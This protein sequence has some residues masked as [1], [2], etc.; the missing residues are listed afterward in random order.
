[1]VETFDK[2]VNDWVE[3]RTNVEECPYYGGR[4]YYTFG[5]CWHKYGPRQCVGQFEIL[6]CPLLVECSINK[7]T[8]VLG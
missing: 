3:N 8:G 2:Q 6:D 1:M 5:R 7:E 4:K